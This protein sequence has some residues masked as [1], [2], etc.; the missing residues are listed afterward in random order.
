MLAHNIGNN[1]GI[2]GLCWE[3]SEV[4]YTATLSDLTLSV[5]THT[6]ALLLVIMIISLFYWL[7]HDLKSLP[8]ILIE[9]WIL[10]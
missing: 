1:L 4:F 3:K 6:A 7:R 10:S 8:E 2:I 9:V 5:V